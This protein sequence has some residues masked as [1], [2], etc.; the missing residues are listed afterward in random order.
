MSIN[1]LITN[2][3]K[4]L[5]QQGF[6]TIE[7]VVVIILIGILATTIIPKMQT[8]GGYEEITYQNETV[9]KLRG[10]QLRT[11][12][13]TSVSQC[14][15]VLITNDKLGIPDDSCSSFVNNNIN[16]TTIVK[17]ID[18]TVNFQYAGGTTPFSFDHLGRP[19][20][21]SSPCQVSIVGQEQT[22][23]VA[24]N[25]QGYIYAVN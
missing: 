2:Q 3:R 14:H 6:T 1:K 16:S 20:N 18:D 21:C 24:I 10:I 13:D 5:K 17:I 22:L 12:Q 23:I 15:L 7:L 19:I 4:L 9:T 8:S 25:E 11:M